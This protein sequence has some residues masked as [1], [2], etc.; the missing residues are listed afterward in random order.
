MKIEKRIELALS[1]AENIVDLKIDVNN[2]YDLNLHLSD[3]LE[4]IKKIPVT[5]SSLQLKEKEV[6]TFDD[7]IIKNIKIGLCKDWTIK[8]II[9]VFGSNS[10]YTRYRDEENL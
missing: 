1:I 8:E 2:L 10:L 7:W 5:H 3:A 6:I 9:K 4:Q